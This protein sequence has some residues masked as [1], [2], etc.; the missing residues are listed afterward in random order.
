[1]GDRNSYPLLA[2][3]ETELTGRW[4]GGGAR[5]DTWCETTDRIYS[6]LSGMQ[7]Y[8]DGQSF[9]AGLYCD[10]RDGR[11][12]KFVDLKEFSFEIRV[13]LVRHRTR[14]GH[15]GV[16]HGGIVDRDEVGPG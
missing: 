10:P 1:M 3:E 13:P 14:G 5:P 4:T 6:L 7:R 12:W 2:P 15:R 16:W 8:L 9:P 11:L